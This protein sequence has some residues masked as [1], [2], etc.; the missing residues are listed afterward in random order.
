M[1]T[2]GSWPLTLGSAMN[3]GLAAWNLADEQYVYAALWAGLAIVNLF[4]AIRIH[5]KRGA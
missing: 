1:S 2:P 4:G 3:V 5:P